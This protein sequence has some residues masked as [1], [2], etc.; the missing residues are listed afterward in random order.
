[1][2]DP[3]ICREQILSED[4]RDFIGNHVR[5]PFFDSIM[6][7]ERCEQ[8]AGYDYKCI[9]LPGAVADPI[10]LSRYSYN[11]IPKCYTPLSMETLTRQAYSPSKIIPHFS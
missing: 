5:T 9:Y 11:S 7:E 6:Q 3:N 2:I 10:T 1:M 8:D 4:Y